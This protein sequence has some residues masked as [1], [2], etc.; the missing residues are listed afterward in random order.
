MK[1]QEENPNGLYF[2]YIVA[3][4]TGEPVDDDAEY[5]VLRL[6]ENGNDPMHI[7]AGRKAIMT[8]AE[9]IKDY[10]PQLSTD[11]IERYGEK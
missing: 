11:L 7:K 4:V 1:T 10:L 5:F 3:K 9:E 2:K 8:Y 6:D